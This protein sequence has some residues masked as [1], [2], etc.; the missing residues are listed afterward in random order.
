M[1]FS[2]GIGLSKPEA[3]SLETGGKEQILP[4]NEKIV[5]QGNAAAKSRMAAELLDMGLSIEA[6][7]RVLHLDNEIATNLK[8]EGRKK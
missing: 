5:G 6:V 3:E 4:R 8:R 2:L 1:K 7:K